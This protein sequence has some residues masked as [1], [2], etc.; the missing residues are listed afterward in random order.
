MLHRATYLL[1]LASAVILMVTGWYIDTVFASQLPVAGRAAILIC[2]V[3]YFL[4]RVGHGMPCEKGTNRLRS[5]I[6][7][8]PKY[9]LDFDA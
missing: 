9:S 7:G 8:S 4:Y 5:Q 2:A 3:V 1:N 6:S